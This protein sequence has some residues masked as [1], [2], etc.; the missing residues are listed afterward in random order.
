MYI[1]MISTIFLAFSCGIF[2]RNGSDRQRQMLGFLVF[3][4]M[5][6]LLMIYMDGSARVMILDNA[7]VG[8]RPNNFA[9]GVLTYMLWTFNARLSVVVS[10]LS[11]LMLTLRRRKKEL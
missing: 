3:L 4:W 5:T 11:L 2:I 6:F 1:L 8:T 7:A 10:A 9:A